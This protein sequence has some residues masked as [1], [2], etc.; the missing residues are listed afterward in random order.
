[1]E[2]SGMMRWRNKDVEMESARDRHRDERDEVTERQRDEERSRTE[3]EREIKDRERERRKE[4][5]KKEALG[6]TNA[7]IL[8]CWPLLQP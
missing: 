8:L 1:M 3:R 6:Q 5:K 4:R 2:E 7:D